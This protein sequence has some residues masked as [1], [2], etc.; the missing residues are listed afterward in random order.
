[1]A[2][3]SG[4]IN[5]TIESTLL[6]HDA[7]QTDI[8][9]LCSAAQWF[10]LYGVCVFPE[11]VALCREFLTG[12][13]VTIVT[14]ANFPGGDN[15][16]EDVLAEIDQSITDGAEEIDYVMNLPAALAGD[17]DKV[18]ADMAAVVAHV[19][20]QGKVV[21]IILET[22]VLTNSQ[23]T[24]ACE[25]ALEHGADF[26]K[27]ST[28]FGSKGATVDAVALM[29]STVGQKAGVKAAGGIRDQE[30]AWAMLNAGAT[31][32]GTSSAMKIIGAE[33]G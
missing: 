13:M 11:H 24:Q 8:D 9:E 32:I 23:I 1:M 28:G 5:Q 22:C 29:Y 15:P 33:R 18:S 26:V 2:A 19:H 31:R 3:F 30:T 17:W 4:I 10:R 27:T 7:S 20:E 25:L 21:K 6:N 16:L 12:N 14:V